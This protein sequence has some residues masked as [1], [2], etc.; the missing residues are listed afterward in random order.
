MILYHISINIPFTSGNDY[1]TILIE[2]P[3]LQIK[4]VNSLLFY[5]EIYINN[6]STG[7]MI[8]NHFPSTWYQN[9]R[10]VQI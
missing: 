9:E 5:F 7:D 2:E 3:F 6:D 10:V 8:S 1:G 4:A